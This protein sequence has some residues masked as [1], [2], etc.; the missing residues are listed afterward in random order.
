MYFIHIAS[1]VVTTVTNSVL[2]F[3]K[4]FKEFACTGDDNDDTV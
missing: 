3:V 4:A 2:N 1:K